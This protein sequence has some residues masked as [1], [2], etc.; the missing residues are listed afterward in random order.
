MS[1][2]LSVNGVVNVDVTLTPIAAAVRNFG[3]LLLLGSS[4]VISTNERMRQYSD[5]T[6]IANDF[7]ESSGEYLAALLHFSQKPQPSMVYIGRWAQIATSGV[8][9]GAVLSALDQAISTWNAVTSGGFN[10]TID[11]TARNVTGLDFSAATNLNGVASIV[12]A[13]IASYATV[14][15]NANSAQFEVTSKS[16]G[17]GAQ[18]TGT[19]TLS[20]NPA[21]NDTLTINGTAV[22]FVSANPAADQVLIGGTAAATAQNLEAFLAASADANLSQCSY[23]LNGSVITVTAIAIGIAGNAITLAKS[24]A[25]ITLSGATLAGGVAVSSVSY[26]TAPGSGTDISAMLGLSQASGASAPVSGI[27][28]ESWLSAVTTLANFSSDWYA[29]HTAATGLQTSDHLAAAAFIEAET[30]SRIY[31]LTTQDPTVLNATATT[32]VCS[33]LKALKYQQTYSQY[34]SSNPYAAVSMFARA[35]TVDFTGI[36][37]TI[38]LKFKQEPGVTAETLTQTQATAL[39]AKNCNVFVNYQNGTAILEQGVM[40]NG[41]FFDEVQGLDWLQNQIQTDVFN[42]FYTSPTKIPQT[43][44]GVTQLINAIENGAAEMAVSNGLCAPGIWNAASIGVVQQGQA[45]SKGYYFYAPSV[46]VQSQ[47]ARAGRQ[48]PTIQGAMKLAGAIHFSD[49]AVSVNR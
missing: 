13:A 14:V 33:Q 36:G 19:V 6:D 28:A 20:A 26:A 46:N 29:I 1:Q 38:T 12:Q 9:A 25:G 39:E 47:S 40:A 31:G 24:S 3:S 43:D 23:S 5:I 7:G 21:A 27:A 4:P 44:A 34:S 8:L 15:W 49:V 2:G 42:V 10:I 11:G 32:D 22:T 17:P 37:T 18:A 48:A 45:L 16:S 30:P 35:A 41:Y